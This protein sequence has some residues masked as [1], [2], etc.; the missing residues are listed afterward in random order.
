MIKSDERIDDLIINGLKIIQSTNQ[1]R[2]SLDAVLLAHFVTLKRDDRILDLGTGSG[3]I[4]LLLTTRAK[5]QSITALEIQPEMV[6]MAQRS[7]A[8]NSLEELISIVHGDIRQVSLT[9]GSNQF[10]LVT[11]N[12][13]YMPLQSGRTNVLDSVTIARHEVLCEL[14]D[15]VKA[16]AQV[17]VFKGR[18]AMVHR[19]NR[20][21]E[22]I[23]LCQRYNLE[24]RR[25]RL[26][27]PRLG[28]K[29]NLV[30]IEAVKGVKPDLEIL[31]NLV[32][33]DSQ[34]YSAEIQAIYGFS[35]NQ[36]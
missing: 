1:F 15:V 2:F 29:P 3:V 17:L 13:P 14:E 32:V 35:D 36:E 12:P 24:P 18:F 28:Q 31:E 4:P 7:V 23:G 27:Q 21:A 26:V 33:Y 6:D 20:L 11:V 25:L 8:L 22:I 16:A 30:L 5:V 19:A 10:D 9:L 34:G